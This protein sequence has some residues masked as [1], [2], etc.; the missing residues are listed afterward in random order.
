MNHIIRSMAAAASLSLIGGAA[1]AQTV[2]LQQ[3]AH[4]LLPTG[5]YVDNYYNGGFAGNTITSGPIQN[6]PSSGAGPKLGFT[7]SLNAEA[8]S[9]GTNSAQ[10]KFATLPTDPN[11]N[12]T[13]VLFFSFVSGNGVTN[14]INFAAGFTAVTFNYALGNNNPMYDQTADVW[15]GLNGTGTLLG[16]IAL[17]SAAVTLSGP[18]RN[19]IFNTWSTA[20][21]NSFSGVAQSVTFGNSNSTPS[22]ELEIDAFTVPEPSSWALII[23]AVPLFFVLRRRALRA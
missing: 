8:L 18:N 2:E 22:E 14:T 11:D 3:N 10:G 7:F 4:D 17:N 19:Y 6:Y 9:A 23:T 16:T 13:Q 5:S 21:D 15:S 12:N 1:N 20:T